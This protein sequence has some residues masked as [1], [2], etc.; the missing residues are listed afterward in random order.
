MATPQIPFIS[1]P[2]KKTDDVDWV[3]PLKKYIAR[4]YQ[5]DPEK[6]KEE[7]Q[8]FNRL[9]QDIRGAGK[10]MTGR[11]LLYRYF[12]QLELLDLRFPVD[13]KHV[14]VIFTWYD[15]FNNRA[16]SQHSLAFEKASV[17]F[18]E[19][20]TL[21]AIASSQNRA[22]TEGRKKA[23][24]YFQAS[25][26]MFQYIND[27]FLHAPS[28]DLS[29]ETVNLLS[30]IML[31]QAQ[32][33]FL[34]SSIRGKSKDGL[35]AK[36]A[37]HVAW[38]YGNLNDG[39]NDAIQNRNV[40]IDKSWSL[41]CQ[42]KQKYYSA[43]AQEH[44]AAACE[45]EGKY[46]ECAGR[47]A[48][49][50]NAAKEAV[51]LANTFA[52]ALLISNH[53]NGTIPSE[54]GAAVQEL[55]KTKSAHCTEKLT[56]ANKDNDMIYHETVPQES[57]LTPIDRLKAVKS[58]PIVEL[59]GPDEMKRVIGA[60]LFSKL[61]PLSVHE[62]AS[63]YSEEIAKLLRAES[64]RCDIA[65]AELNASLDY[66]KLPGSLAKFKN[67]Q[68]TSTSLDAFAE[69]PSNVKDWAD[70]I[71]VEERTA[72]INDLI[73][74]ITLLKKQAKQSLDEA[75]INL[76]KEMRDCEQNR[77]QYG[78]Q[79]TQ[80]PSGSLTSQFRQDISNHRRTLDSAAQSDNQL[81]AKYESARRNLDILREGG[82]SL[83]LEKTYTQTLTSLISNNEH[84]SKQPTEAS[85]L[86][87]DFE[88][89]AEK[90]QSSKENI[91]EKVQRV[92]TTID[93]LRRIEKD[94]DDTFHD[95]KEKTM[96][97]DISQ[98]LI[99]NKKA[100]VEQQIFASEL[101]KYRAHQQRISATIQHQQQAIQELT[102]AFKELMEGDEAKTLQLQYD[103]AERLRRNLTDELNEARAI[104]YEVKDGLNRG[105]QFYSNIRTT[106]DSLQA[107]ISR[108]VSERT[109]ERNRLIEEM[110]RNK[111]SQEQE[112]LRE[113]LNKYTSAASAPPPPA[114]SAAAPPAASY[115]QVSPSHAAPTAP[116]AGPP[117]PPPPLQS[118]LSGSSINSSMAH[119]TYQARQLSISEPTVP[120]SYGGYTPTPPPKPQGIF[121]T[122]APHQQQPAPQPPMNSSPSAVGYGMYSQPAYAP[123]PSAYG[124]TSLPVHQSPMQTPV[125]Y[126][127]NPQP[128]PYS[129]QPQPPMQNYYGVQRSQPTMP[130]PGQQPGQYPLPSPQV[131]PQQQQHLSFGYSGPPPPTSHSHGGP[132]Q[133]PQYPQYQQ[134]NPAAPSWQQHQ[135]PPQLQP[136]PQYQPSQ[137]QWQQQPY[138]MQPMPPMQPQ[139]QQQQQQQRPPTS[140][141][142]D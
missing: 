80:P 135:Q 43:T 79:W 2:F 22:E 41:L 31:A 53:A 75:S 35:I 94:R 131:P 45:A 111:S 56:T 97:D 127:T 90:K 19:A 15:A 11:D 104:Y 71:A 123:P 1:A 39:I 121:Q 8:A 82:Q 73:N 116:A 60:D 67:Q 125:T 120:S 59:Y 40:H 66:M 26:G 83:T 28:E 137:P 48:A 65:K 95:L 14:K 106:I 91:N 77:V 16:I 69:P 141:L 3:H 138:P 124:Q 109:N 105:V 70:Q 25:S 118:T 51:K 62:S 87:L 4:V 86:D 78:D 89:E 9:R 140:N 115:T 74:S 129:S 42:L 112:M 63:L 17:I 76:D 130:P 58:I 110:E 10:D 20:A 18:N 119:L 47:Y 38:V 50:E 128:S 5:D 30:E 57:I 132:P 44:K 21:S 126:N 102:I 72:S 27:N 142:L 114:V 133:Q 96:Q 136:Q 117:P 103:K 98:L 49:A 36:L 46:G 101:E 68:E 13:E 84:S 92:E 134:N 93:K 88:S 54:A 55:C 113:T 24:H 99:L 107:N 29:R 61:I 37:S 100:N 108:F 6:Y 7:T 122:P 33:C 139:Q 32:E 23:F 52:S 85:L 64:E 81:I 34:E 12:G